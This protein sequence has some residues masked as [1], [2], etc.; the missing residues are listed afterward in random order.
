[1]SS[2]QK[3]IAIALLAAYVFYLVFVKKHMV[4]SNGEGL[5]QRIDDGVAF[6][7]SKFG[8]NP[9]WVPNN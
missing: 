2:T 9:N 8:Y 5:P 3:N 4:A 7:P 6:D 1:M